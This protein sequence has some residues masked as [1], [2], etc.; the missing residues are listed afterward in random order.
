MKQCATCGEFKNESEYNWRNKLLGKR[1]GTC[2]DCQSEQK[3][4][5]CENNRERHVANMYEQR[6]SKQDVGREY[7]W[8]HLSTHPCVDCGQSYPAVLEFHHVRGVKRKEVTRLVRDGYSI[9]TIQKEIDK[10]DVVCANCH[11]LRTYKDSWRDQ[12]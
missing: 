9:K 7:I 10:C 8:N 1:W 11:K 5:W 12:W 4:K 2:R 6:L 3:K